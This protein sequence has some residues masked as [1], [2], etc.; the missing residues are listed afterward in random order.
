MRGRGADYGGLKYS[1]Y[2]ECI[3]CHGFYGKT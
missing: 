2:F 3:D 1:Q